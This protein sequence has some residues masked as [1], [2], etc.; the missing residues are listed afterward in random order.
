MNNEMDMETRLWA[1]IDGMSEPQEISVVE[2]L[3]AENGEWR[4]RYSELLQVHSLLNL[5][6][7]EQPSLRF[8]KNVMEDIAKFNIAP[9]A[10]SYINTKII[11]SIGLFFMVMIVGLLVYGFGQIDWSAGSSAQS[12]TG[13]DLTAVDYSPIFSNSFIN[14]FI[15]L[16]I[17][18]GLMLLDRFL[19]KKREDLQKGF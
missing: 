5:T 18:L 12:S 9:A 11:W 3:I 16:N 14:L 1:Y 4:A 2:R 8:T 17:V 10:K 19:A 7:L 15:V 13:I 6:E